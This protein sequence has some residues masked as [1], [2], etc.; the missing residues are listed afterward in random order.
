[1]AFEWFQSRK[2]AARPQPQIGESPSPLVTGIPLIRLR[3]LKKSYRSAAGEVPVLRGINL[4]IYPGEF[5]GILGKSGSGK[6]TLLNMIAGIDRPTSGEVWIKD[7][8]IHQLTEGQMAVWR[9]RN[10]GIIFQ[11]FQLLPMLSLLDNVMLPMDFSKMYTIRQR[12]ERALALLDMVEMVDHAYKL[13]SAISGGQQQRVA[14]ARALANDPPLIVADE[15]T[16]NLD[17][18]TAQ[19]VFDLF[20]KFVD[21]GK[22]FVIVTH[23]T[24]LAE[25]L[26]RAAYIA[27][28][29]IVNDRR[30]A[31]PMHAP[32]TRLPPEVIL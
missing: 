18:K 2:A 7:T 9:G 14:I 20:Q 30:Q 17:S 28:G 15:P 10:L 29:Q 24:T 16:G 32:M 3:D 21:Q 4:D 13:P 11:F 8:P 12:H 1:M 23:D 22:T 27:D 31:D 6:T 19:S 26:S 5:V 25:R